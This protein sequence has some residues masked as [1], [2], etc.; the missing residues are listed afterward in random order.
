MPSPL[1]AGAR[2]DRLVVGFDLAATFV[3]ALEGASSGVVA[4]LDLLGVFALGFVTA[5][6]GGIIRDLIIGDVPPAAFRDQR[7]IF[8]ALIGAAIGFV[9]FEPVAE[10]PSGILIALDAAGL[11][12]F[13]VSGASKS[14]ELGANPV[15]AVIL[16]AVTGTG[17][18][19]LRDVL[20]N[21]VPAVLRIDIYASA[22]LLGAAVM[23]VGVRRGQP[24]AWMMVIGGGVCFG[25]RAVA[26]WQH[27]GLPVA[28]A[29]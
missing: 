16:G 12:L 9:V 26:A 29:L 7:Y 27:W 20:L 24:R 5:V 19:V 17:G 13:A 22:A 2:P 11:S 21:R 23:T 1:P 14:L 6:G 25:L 28:G 10:V 15:R 4:R 3:F 18:G 8:T